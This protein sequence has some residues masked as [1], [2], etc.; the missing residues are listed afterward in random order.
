MKLELLPSMTSEQLAHLRE[1]GITSCR[2][3]MRA[4]QRPER[5]ET[6]AHNAGLSPRILKD[7]VHL[8]ELSEIRGVGPAML[9][10]LLEIGVDSPARM[11]SLDPGTLQR[12]LQRVVNPPPNL[13]V[14][15]N[16]ISQARQQERRRRP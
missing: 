13:A 5:L 14:I 7:L 16:W 1:L 8:A 11:G 6:L 2:H 9:A 4:G 15:E 3:L 10:C 12:R